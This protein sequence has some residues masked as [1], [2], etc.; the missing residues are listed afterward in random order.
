MIYEDASLL[1]RVMT[2]KLKELNSSTYERK[3]PLKTFKAAPKSRQLSPFEQKLRTL[4]DAI[5]DYR[6]PK[7][8]KHTFRNIP[9][10][11]S[12]DFLVSLVVYIFVQI[13]LLIFNLLWT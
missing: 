11:I 4:Y 3:T 5:R 1:E 7:G 13:Y 8:N 6:D 2:E 12:D 10:S 9:R